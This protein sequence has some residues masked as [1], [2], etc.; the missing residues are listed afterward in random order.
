MA[1]APNDPDAYEE[2]GLALQRS[3]HFSASIA[4]Y[5]KSIELYKAKAKAE[6]IGPTGEFVTDVADESMDLGDVY[7]SLGDAANARKTFDQAVRYAAMIPPNSPYKAM[8]QRTI[9]RSVEAMAAV[10]LA[11]H[12]G[13]TLSLTKWSGADLP[14]SL[15]S[16]Y[17][18]RLI[19]IAPANKNV[20]LAAAGVHAGWV[21]SFCADGLC[22]PKTVSFVTPATGIKTYEFQLVPPQDGAVPGKVV[23]S[24]GTSA[25]AAIP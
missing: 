10:A 16:T 21:A 9:D 4:P 20:T 18:Y 6:P 2:L 23:V 12:H 19:V 7:V 8:R 5:V 24:A 3:R 14:G 15:K 13:T 17:K 22:S 1:L 25:T 11:H